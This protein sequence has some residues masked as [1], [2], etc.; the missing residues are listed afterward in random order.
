MTAYDI[1]RIRLELENLA[2]APNSTAKGN[3]LQHLVSYVLS[4]IPGVVIRANNVLDHARSDEK[5]LWVRHSG[6]CGLPFSDLYLPV[7]CKNEQRATSASEV[8]DFAA[9]IRTSSGVDGILVTRGGLTGSSADRAHD[10]IHLEL[11]SGIRI[12]VITCSDI[13]KLTEPS[14]LVTLLNDRFF[15]LRSN[16]TYVTI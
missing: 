1:G 6:M 11:A 10:V 2:V 8:R 5:D 9:K 12:T 3:N 7:E 16:K 13:A 4:E 14:D 15:E